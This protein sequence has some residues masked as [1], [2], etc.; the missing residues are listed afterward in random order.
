[1]ARRRNV[2]LSTIVRTFVGLAILATA[3]VVYIVLVATKPQP[4]RSEVAGNAPRVLVFAAQP[5]EVRRQWDGY[6]TARAMDSADVPARVTATV[7]GLAA[8]I[9]AGAWVEK[10]Q[11]LVQLDDSDFARQVELAANRIAD[12]DAQLA[13][14]EI[15]RASWT[16][17]KE[18]AEERVRL[19]REEFD[20][21]ANAQKRGAAKQREVDFARQALI[22]AIRDEV[23]AREEFDKLDPRKASLEAQGHALGVERRLAQQNVERCR[24]TSP[25]DGV[26][27]SV[28]VEVGENLTA[29]QRVARV[30]DLRRIEVPL[31]LPASARA[32]LRVGDDV[33]LRVT[34]DSDRFWVARVVRVAPDDDETTRTMGAYVEIEQDPGAP[35]GVAPGQFL[36]GTVASN[37]AERRSVVPRRSVDADRILLVVDNHVAVRRIDVQF[38]IETDLPALGVP[39]RL[40]VVLE[41][42]LDDGALVV[43]HPSRALPEGLPVRPVVGAG[44]VRAMGDGD[45]PGDGDAAGGLP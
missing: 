34:D 10:G 11:L 45:G 20:R 36:R 32:D 42:P 23:A 8:E 12:I 43:L 5:V 22:D 19:V 37:R 6:G 29:G 40:W 41:R 28:D 33:T 27:Q 16:E 3:V 31:R 21:V 44:G 17:R 30:V 25:L 26:L 13:R 14:L 15:E 18:L 35:G 24:I 2:F 1:M 7:D 4:T 39:D 38:Q 9:V